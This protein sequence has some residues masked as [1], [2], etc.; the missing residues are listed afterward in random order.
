MDD[1]IPNSHKF[2]EEQKKESSLVATERKEKPSIQKVTKGK[3]KT[4]K[5]SEIRKFADVFI[6]EDMSKVKS[7][8][9]GE[10]IIPTIKKAIC[11]I[12]SN[13]IEM[14]LWGET[15]H[16]KRSSSSKISY[17]NYYDSRRSDS[18]RSEYSVSSRY[19]VDDVI[20]ESREEA[21]EVLERMDELI[22]MYGVASIADFYD[23]AGVTGN[24]TDNKYGWTNLSAADVV[25]VRDGYMIKLPRVRPL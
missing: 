12:V 1:F 22:D 4:K 24:Y 14:I 25:R 7:Y 16:R 18:H 13:G 21:K 15:G 17:S 5:K 10:V 8:A 6:A 20:F 3:V 2:K 9:L 19:D 23:L 11:D